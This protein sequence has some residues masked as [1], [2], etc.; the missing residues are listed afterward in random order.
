MTQPDIDRADVLITQVHDA[1]DK[2]RD[3]IVVSDREL[4]VAAR[5]RWQAAEKEL[6]ELLRQPSFK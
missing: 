1:L 3:A 2:M 6:R 5:E 4:Y